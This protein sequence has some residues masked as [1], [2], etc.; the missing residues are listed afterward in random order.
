MRQ[1][2]SYKPDLT[3]QFSEIGQHVCQDTQN[4]AVDKEEMNGEF[5]R[6]TV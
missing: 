3:L 4:H 1:T 2:T 5:S 6:G